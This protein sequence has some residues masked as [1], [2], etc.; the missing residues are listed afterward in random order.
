MYEW[1]LSNSNQTRNQIYEIIFLNPQ[2]L[3]HL[4]SR[5]YLTYIP[6]A[7]VIPTHLPI[8]VYTTVS[9]RIYL[10]QSLIN[11][12][13]NPKFM[14]LDSVTEYTFLLPLFGM[15]KYPLYLSDIQE[16]LLLNTLINCLLETTGCLILCTLQP[17]SNW[18][19]PRVNQL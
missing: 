19:G 18:S 1:N 16:R 7:Q 13:S 17:A 4:H 14:L 3:L 6:H 2:Y 12:G 5:T 10:A 8:V 9:S 15:Y 11:K